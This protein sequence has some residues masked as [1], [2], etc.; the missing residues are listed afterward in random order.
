MS[1]LIDETVL[2]EI[3]RTK[4]ESGG[5]RG[6]L[7]DELAGD[8]SNLSEGARQILKF[9][10]SYEQEDRDQRRERKRAGLE[11]AYQYMVRGKLP[12][13]TMTARQ[14]LAQ[15]ELA[16]RYGDGTL[17]ITTRQAFQ[18]YGIVKR[19][20]RGTIHDLNEALITTF[21]SCGDVVRNVV[22]CSAPV[23]GVGGTLRRQVARCARRV[24][25]ELL[26]RTRAYHEIWVEGARVT[27]PVAV[28]EDP[29]Y[30]ARYLPRKFKIGFA[31]PDDNCVDVFA[32]DLGFVVIAEEDR[33][34]GFNV[35]VGGGLGQTHNKPDTYPRLASPLGFVTEEELL[36]TAR[37]VVAVQRDHGN[38]ENRRRARLK[39]LLDERGVDWFRE[40]VEA[41]L[42]RPLAPY[43][44][45]EVTGFQDHLGWHPQEDGRWFRGVWVENGRIR[46]DET[47]RLRTAL[48]RIVERFRPDVY[49][50]TQQNLLLV[51]IDASDRDPIDGLLRAHGMTAPERLTPVRRHAMACPAL[52]TCPLAVA[53]SERALPG[54]IGELEVALSRI[55]VAGVPLAVRMTGCPNGCARPY[56]ADLS[57]VGRSLGKYQVYVG[58]NLDGNRL[59]RLYADLV[60]LHE[61]VPLVEPLFERFRDERHPGEGFGDFWDRVGLE[62]AT[63][64]GRGGGAG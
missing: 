24:S 30:G 62:A 49:L 16:D 29:V 8:R 53:E 64:A 22:S 32:N 42:G 17:R 23:G 11:P 37:A 9:H 19:D 58:G 50:T 27:V 26:P 39:Y 59:A 55:G 61:I 54:L 56:T 48:R 25:D 44:D 20:L 40:E 43:R 13:G 7:P 28:D 46:D 34:A 36:E 2:T 63:P 47:V 38:R 6:S 45:V 33:I 57:F 60:P 21:G 1:T 31:F 15:D 3:E 18:F 12:A 14:F 4:A 5:L 51:G 10:G 52:P 35:L 41:R